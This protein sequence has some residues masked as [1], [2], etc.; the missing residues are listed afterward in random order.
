MRHSVDGR[1][2]GRNTPHRKAMFKNMANSVIEQEQIITTVQKAK[3]AKR[4]V[5]RLITL[6]KKGTLH[7][8][9]LAFARTRSKGVVEKLFGTLADRYQARPGGYTRVLRLSDRRR[10][11]SAEMALFELVDHPILTRKRVKP[12]KVKPGKNVD[13][14]AEDVTPEQFNEAAMAQAEASM[15]RFKKLFAG[16]K[17]NRGAS[18]KTDAKTIETGKTKNTKSAKSTK[19]SKT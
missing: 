12:E 9:R 14:K 7:A 17:R 11:D 13:K 8:R 2:F 10:G 6:G 15:G 1:K 16:K 3:E 19:K 18:G 5:D 4:V